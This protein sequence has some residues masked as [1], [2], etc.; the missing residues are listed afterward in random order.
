MSL[1]VIFSGQGLQKYEQLAELKQQMNADEWTAFDKAIFSNNAE[2]IFDNLIAQP[3]IFALQHHRYH[4]LIKKVGEPTVLAGYSLGEVSA[5]CCSMQTSFFQGLE[6]IKMRAH[7]MQEAIQTDGG[8][9]FIQGLNSQQMDGLI[10]STGTY[11]SIK[12]SETRHI[13][14]GTK[15]NL[16]EA[17]ASAVMLGAK[18]VKPLDVSIA[19]H[20]P[21]MGMADELFLHYLH[22]QCLPKMTL[23]IISATDACKYED[24]HTAKTILAQQISHVL[25][26]QACMEV[27]GEHQPEVILEIGPGNALARMM[28]EVMPEIPCRSYDDFCDESGVIA[29]LNKYLA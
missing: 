9:M 14:A 8:L 4:S 11:L 16:N 28:S 18:Q 17:H 5:W 12:Q 22:K 24:N 10:Q 2:A 25:D 15:S 29:W 21:L 19:S 3:F 6:V 1:V 20:S 7:L 26:W 23:P 13:I 27:I